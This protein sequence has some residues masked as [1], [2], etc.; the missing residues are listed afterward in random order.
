MGPTKIRFK[1]DPGHN[2]PMPLW[3]PLV[4]NATT[5]QQHHQILIIGGGNAG[6]SVAAQLLRKRKSLQIAIMEPSE[7]HFDPPAWTLVGAGTCDIPETVRSEASVMP[8]GVNWIKE[9]AAKFEPESN[10]VISANGNEYTYDYLIVAPGIQLNWHQ[11]KGL[12][13]TLGRNGVTSN[14]SFDLAPY[15][16]ELL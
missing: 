4:F 3:L 9:A 13:E 11:V 6:I 5:M 1:R 12:P 10:K 2:C 7:K 8:S 14:Y 15:T 16:F